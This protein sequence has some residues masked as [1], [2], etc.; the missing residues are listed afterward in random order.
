MSCVEAIELQHTLDH[1]R[2]VEAR[3]SRPGVCAQASPS[4]AASLPPL[5][6]RDELRQ[7]AAKAGTSW[8]GSAAATEQGSEQVSA[9]ACERRPRAPAGW[10]PRQSDPAHG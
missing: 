7:V 1:R 10:S 6:R 8:L 3:G 2:R 5:I 4:R 9:A